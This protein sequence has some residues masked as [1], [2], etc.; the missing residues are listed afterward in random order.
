MIA[1]LGKS[2]PGKKTD[3]Q[4]A[5]VIFDALKEMNIRY[6]R[7]PNIPFYKDD[8]VQF[9]SETLKRGTGDCDDMVILYASLLEGI[10][11]KTVFVEV[12][13][14]DKEPAHLYLMFDTGIEP[15]EGALLTSNEKRYVIRESR[16]SKKTIWIPVE[17]TLIVNGFD[18]AWEE[19][20]MHYLKEGIIRAGIANGWV[21]LIDHN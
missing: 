17:T 19:G 4:K 2:E 7:D 14:P 11:I 5:K 15:Q 1:D 12:R 21:R 13:D 8:Y 18:T 20:A 3:F 9:A 16:N 10:G 6:Q